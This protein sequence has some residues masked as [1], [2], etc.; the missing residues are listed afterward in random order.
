MTWKVRRYRCPIIKSWRRWWRE[1]KIWNSDHETLT[2]EMKRVKRVVVKNR[3]GMSAVEGGKGICYPWKEE[4]QCSKW[5]HCSFRHESNDH[6]QN[7]NTMPP[8]LLSHPCH[9]VEVCR[10]KEV[11]EAKVILVSFFDS[12]AD[13]IWKVLALDRL[14][15]IRIRPSANYIKMKRVVK[16]VISVCS[17]VSRLTNNQTKKKLPFP[18]RKRTRRQ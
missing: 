5:D 9:E 10:G 13:I 3:K 15:N 18:K 8:H 14:V 1:A 16:P 2:P 17:R 6:A 7:Q 12:R 4:G 11:S